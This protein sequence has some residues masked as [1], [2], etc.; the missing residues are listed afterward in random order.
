VPTDKEFQL[1]SFQWQGQDLANLVQALKLKEAHNKA[2]LKNPELR[3][4]EQIME[5]KFNNTNSKTK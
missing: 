5:E 3:K 2:N 4:I 1:L